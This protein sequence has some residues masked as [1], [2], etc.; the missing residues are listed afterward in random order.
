MEKYYLSYEPEFKA[1]CIED[2]YIYAIEQEYEIPMLG[3]N[4]QG[5]KLLGCPIPSADA[6][7]I[8]FLLGRDRDCYSAGKNY[9]LALAKL[10]YNLR[11]LTYPHCK[12]QL[13]GCHGLCLPGGAFASPEV[14]YTDAKTK[15]TRF[16]SARSKAYYDCI[17]LALDMNI[18]ILGICAGAQMI[19]GCFGL[20]LYRNQSYLETPLKHKNTKAEAHRLN[21]FPDTPLA[22]ILKSNNQMFINSR[23]KEM[24]APLKIQK[25]LW[26]QKRRTSVEKVNLPL[27]FYAEA[28]DGVPEAWGSEEDHILC[29]QWHPEDMVADGNEQMM[30]IFRWLANE[31]K[32]QM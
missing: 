6:P 27:D 14:Y 1:F 32:A 3:L 4:E 25:E 28:N 7:V 23:H 20:K 30:E 24:A 15:K 12:A 11:F 5:Y 19:A 8:G 18:P 10:G 31:I 29:V 26:A 16:P 9:V 21:V 22:K 13:N 17:Q 2:A